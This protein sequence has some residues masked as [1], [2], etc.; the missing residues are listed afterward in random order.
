MNNES[1]VT[2]VYRNAK[3]WQICFFALNNSATN[4]ALMLMMQ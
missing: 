1:S 3:T 4:L 2:P